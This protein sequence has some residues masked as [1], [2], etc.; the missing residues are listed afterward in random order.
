MHAAASVFSALFEALAS[1][2]GSKNEARGSAAGTISH[3]S[4]GALIL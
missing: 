1:S 2:D 3:Y 4:L